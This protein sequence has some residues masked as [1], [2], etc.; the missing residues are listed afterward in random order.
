MLARADADG[1][2]RLTPA[3]A[4]AR[5]AACFR[6]RRGRDRRP[7]LALLLVPFLRGEEVLHRPAHNVRPRLGARDPLK[8]EPE[9]ERVDGG[10]DRPLLEADG[11]CPLPVVHIRAAAEGRPGHRP[12]VET[13]LEARRPIPAGDAYEIDERADSLDSPVARV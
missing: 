4:S 11:L 7:A 3:A 10:D 8:A 6:K 13:G 2:R 9:A 5:P 1:Q 12:A